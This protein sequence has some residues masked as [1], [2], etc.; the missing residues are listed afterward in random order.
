ME[1][2]YLQCLVMDNGEILCSGQTIGWVKDLGKYLFT[3]D[4]GKIIPPSIRVPFLKN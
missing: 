4:K 2:K 3:V 1:V